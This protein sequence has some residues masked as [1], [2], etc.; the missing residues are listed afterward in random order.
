MKIDIKGIL[1]LAVIAGVFAFFW[2]APDDGLQAA[3][4]FDMT[5]ID[6]EQLGSNQLDGKP[7]MV[8]FWATDCP[9]CVKEIPHLNALY[10]EFG[11]QGF[12][13]IAV[14]MPHDEL[15]LIKTMRDQKAMDYEIV[16]DTD[17][18]IAKTFGG[19][20]VTPT[21]FLISPEGKIALHKMGE[22]DTDEVH[23]LISNML[24]G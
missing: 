4:D 13:V 23:Q 10:N 17:G 21:N 12:K 14:A 1:L 2:L 9:G 15:P 5:T 20:I 22:F 18:M 6:G 8:V 16:F 3:P 24:K 7:Y 11:D 19:V